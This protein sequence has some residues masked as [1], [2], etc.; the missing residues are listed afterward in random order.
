MTTQR[1]RTKTVKNSK[2]SNI[3]PVTCRYVTKT[4][5]RCYSPTRELKAML[6]YML[7][8]NS[9]TVSARFLHTD[10]FITRL[11]RVV[12]EPDHTHPTWCFFTRETCRR[13]DCAHFSILRQKHR[14]IP[15]VILVSTSADM[16]R[17]C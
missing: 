4:E 14:N 1:Q 12:A 15:T 2:Q 9:F 6:Q 8:F 13:S 3:H 5:K 17:T 16:C 7:F 11:R 10:L